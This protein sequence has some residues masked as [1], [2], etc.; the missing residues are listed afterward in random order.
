MPKT[1]AADGK[2]TSGL[3]PASPTAKQVRAL[4]RKAGLSQTEA[5]MQVYK[6]LRQW[7]RWEADSEAGCPM[8]AATWELFVLKMRHKGV[9]LPKYL[10]E[11]VA[12]EW[13]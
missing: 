1:K 12:A 2:T 11:Y 6:E 8:P 5:A 3:P 4:R 10:E 9:R 13:R 7:Q